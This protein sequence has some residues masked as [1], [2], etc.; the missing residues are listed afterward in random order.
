MAI[1]F[2]CHTGTITATSLKTEHDYS[3]IAFSVCLSTV[4]KQHLLPVGIVPNIPTYDFF[5]L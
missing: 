2:V 1:A 5:L 3:S 4:L